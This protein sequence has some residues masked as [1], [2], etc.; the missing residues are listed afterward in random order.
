MEPTV[1]DIWMAYVVCGTERITYCPPYAKYLVKY[2][3]TGPEI[4]EER[5]NLRENE[6][7]IDIGGSLPIV[8]KEDPM[9]WKS[10]QDGTGVLKHSFQVLLFGIFRANTSRITRRKCFK[11]CCECKKDFVVADSCQNDTQK[12]LCTRKPLGKQ[13]MTSSITRG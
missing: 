3:T 6:G 2:I 10:M 1:G 12:R 5:L 13:K 9:A 4:A 8:L 11:V 7:F